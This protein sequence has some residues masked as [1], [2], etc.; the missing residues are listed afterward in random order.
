MAIKAFT[1]RL[2]SEPLLH[3]MLIGLAI[4]V[5]YGTAKDPASVSENKILLS[6]GDVANLAQS[7]Q[8][9]WNR[10]PTQQELDGLIST[11]I[12]E[13]ILY[14]E[15]LKL[16][17][18]VNDTIVRRRL[19]QKMDFLF[20]D[21]AQPG[22]PS[23]EVLKDY[24]AQNTDRFENPP[25]FSFDHVYLS[26]DKRGPNLESDGARILEELRHSSAVDTDFAAAGDRF[27]LEQRFVDYSQREISRLMGSRFA[28][29]LADVKPGEWTGPI[30]SG[31][32][33]HL[34]IIHDYVPAGM[35]EFD[36]I[37][38]QVEMEY[39]AEQLRIANEALFN[40]L[41]SNYEIVVEMPVQE[42]DSKED[43][44]ISSET[45]ATSRP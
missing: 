12:R 33:L 16:G 18:D 22:K 35:P 32:G 15:A 4:F 14:R 43:T 31:Y 25:R 3:F 2:L 24:V 45:E 23:D 21:L 6:A 9:R 26:P 28:E 1:K 7:W 37:R 11:Y 41:K 5:L 19:A 34:V 8:T 36:L 17:L 30:H 13:Q 40:E 27:M 38:G 20:R 29:A 42:I 39:Q 44:G 10:P